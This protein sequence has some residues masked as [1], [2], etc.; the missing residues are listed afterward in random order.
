MRKSPMTHWWG[1]NIDQLYISGHYTT[2]LCFI[3]IYGLTQWWGLSLDQ[4]H[5]SGHYTTKFCFTSI[6]GLHV[7]TQCVIRIDIWETNSTPSGNGT[8]CNQ[9]IISSLATQHYFHH[10]YC[11]KVGTK[12]SPPSMHVGFLKPG[13]LEDLRDWSTNSLI[14]VMIN[15]TF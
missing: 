4:H 13:A 1:L 8:S 15:Q 3:S 10:L 11:R 2:K 12:L 5:N 7:F 9:C 6:H 14:H